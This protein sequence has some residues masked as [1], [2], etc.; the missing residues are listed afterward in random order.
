[1]VEGQP[2]H[3]A[4][5]ELSGP[6]VLVSGGVGRGGRDRSMARRGSA[7]HDQ[8]PPRAAEANRP[9]T[10]GFWGLGDA[11]ESKVVTAIEGLPVRGLITMKALMSGE[12]MLLL[13]LTYEAGAGAQPHLHDH[14]SHCYV[15]SG[16]M[17]A[18]VAGESRKMGPGDA[19]L[20]PSGRAPRDGGDR[21]LRRGRDKV[22]E[23]RPLA[24]S[25]LR[26]EASIRISE[27]SPGP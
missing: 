23:A 10:T 26:R 8:P 22:P 9:V 11:T 6:E 16:R 19:C 24:L 21:A 14:E 3:T 25:Q 2:R 27:L 7:P 5:Y 17:R 20:H 1:M 12:H 15:V 18:T 13:E 4:I